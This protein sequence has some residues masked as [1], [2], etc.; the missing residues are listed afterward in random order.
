[1]N[2]A[3]LL[4][5][6]FNIAYWH[7][8]YHS[9]GYK[10]RDESLPVKSYNRMINHMSVWINEKMSVILTRRSSSKSSWRS[11]S[12]PGHQSLHPGQPLLNHQ[13]YWQAVTKDLSSSSK[14]SGSCVLTLQTLPKRKSVC[15]LTRLQDPLKSQLLT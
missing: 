7:R 14:F 6:A 13:N 9:G 3:F 8:K 5:T 10:P 4:G 15:V 2:P 12:W 1:M 11:D